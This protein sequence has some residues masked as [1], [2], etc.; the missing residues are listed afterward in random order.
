MTRTIRLASFTPAQALDFADGLLGWIDVQIGLLVVHGVA[1][2]R[3][4]GGALTLSW[5]ARDDRRGGRRS[6]VRPLDDDARRELE[7]RVLGELRRRR[8]AS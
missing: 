1:V 4:R 3:T 2:R 8:I 5:P 7:R 6:V